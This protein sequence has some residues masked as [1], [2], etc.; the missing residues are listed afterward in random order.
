MSPIMKSKFLLFWHNEYILHYQYFHWKILALAGIWTWDLPGTK[1]ICYQ[2]SYPGLDKFSCSV[3]YLFSHSVKFLAV[4]FSIYSAVWI[5]PYRQ[6][7]YYNIKNDFYECMLFSVIF[8]DRVMN[9]WLP[10][11]FQAIFYLVISNF[12]FIFSFFPIVIYFKL[13]FHLQVSRLGNTKPAGN[14]ISIK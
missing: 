1:P 7:R 12:S 6:V 4:Q 14:F 10:L 8:T 3:F 13:I 11:A 2:L 9:S 5:R